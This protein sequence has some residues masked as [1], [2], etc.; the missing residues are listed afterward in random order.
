M[1]EPGSG[2]A[3][4]SLSQA[5]RGYVATIT[6]GPRRFVFD[7]AAGEDLG[8]Y[9]GEY[10]RQGCIRVMRK[11]T[12]LTVY[13]RPDIGLAR[14][15]VVVELG[16][17]WLDGTGFEPAHITT[18]Y[19]CEIQSQGRTVATVNVP[20]HL[21][22]ARWRWQSAPRPV[23]RSPAVLL[24]RRLIAPYGRSG[25]YGARSVGKFVDWQG[26]MDT[27]SVY[28]M[29]KAGGDRPD[30]GLMTEYQAEYL[31]NGS[32]AALA[33]VLAQGEAC[34]T[35]PIHWRDERTGAFADVYQYPRMSTDHVGRPLLP[36]G[37]NLRLSGPESPL[38]PR[39][40]VYDTS[41]APAASYLPFVLTDDPFFLEEL[42]AQG[43]FAILQHAWGHDRYRL[44]GLVLA[45]QTRAFAWGMREL[46]QL[47]VVAPEKPPRW[48][49]GRGYW[50]RCIADN[51][52]FTRLYMQSPA[53]V[54]KV[55]RAFPVA[56]DENGGIYPWQNSYMAVALGAGVWMGYEDWREFYNW[57]CKGITSL[58]NGRSGWNRE[59]PTPYKYF[60]IRLP[61][62]R[63]LGLLR[64]TSL[65]AETAASWGEAWTWF[66]GRQKI[67]D[68]GWDGSSLMIPKHGPTYL[69]YLRGSL[70]LATHLG[71]AEAKECYDFIAGR[72][73]SWMAR[74]QYQGNYRWSID[75]A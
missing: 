58:C 7:S 14:L 60:P 66:K 31:I 10:V 27:A 67:D 39:Y 38:D 49:N 47:G 42:E 46:F 28:T 48:L 62:P 11:D 32:P 22:W 26:P 13:F 75:P 25:L 19:T 73:P 50:R 63:K 41:H 30:I 54:H 64:D 65:D 9:S 16:R 70:A 53:R 69:L 29:M 71:V 52:A 24:Q 15:E 36:T 5:R 45:G 51:L 61:R 8:A 56:S 1:P 55:F 34:G 57:F 72:L 43:S 4:G 21:W 2:G 6:L 74:A 23:V 44:P 3:G 35:M 33:S 59:W 12:P 40:F 68:S 37:P 20:Y 17:I 18:P